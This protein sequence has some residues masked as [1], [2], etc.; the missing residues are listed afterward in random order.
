MGGGMVAGCR[1]RWH[2]HQRP[3]GRQCPLSMACRVGRSPSQRL[4]ARRR[5]F[6]EIEAAL[7]RK[8]AVKVEWAGTVAVWKARQEHAPRLCLDATAKGFY[9]G[10]SKMNNERGEGCQGQ[11][12]RHQ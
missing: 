6:R 1:E 9:D 7:A 4:L 8:E 12:K 10:G 3:P 11:G 2:A 5:D